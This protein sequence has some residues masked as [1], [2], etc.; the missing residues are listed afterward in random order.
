MAQLIDALQIV[1][2]ACLAVT[3]GLVCD[4]NGTSR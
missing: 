1:L 4:G 3:L 2:T